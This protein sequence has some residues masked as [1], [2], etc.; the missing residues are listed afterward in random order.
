MIQFRYVANLYAP[1]YWVTNDQNWD[2]YLRKIYITVKKFNLGKE[3]WKSSGHHGHKILSFNNKSPKFITLNAN[4]IA[5]AFWEKLLLVTEI[6]KFLTAKP[7]LQ[8]Y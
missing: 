2:S 8:I 1:Q 3:I 6:L 5:R 4:T 7:K